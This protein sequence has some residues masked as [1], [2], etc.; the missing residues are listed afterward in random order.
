MR[1]NRFNCMST[2][3]LV[4]WLDDIAMTINLLCE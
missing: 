1:Q 4:D 3:L 2:P